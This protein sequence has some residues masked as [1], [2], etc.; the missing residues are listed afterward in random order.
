MRLVGL[1]SIHVGVSARTKKRTWTSGRK[2]QP[3]ETARRCHP[4]CSDPSSRKR[5]ARTCSN[6]LDCREQLPDIS[7]PN[8]N[9]N[10]IVITTSL[11]IQ[12]HHQIWV[13]TLA[14]FGN[15]ISSCRQ[16]S[17]LNRIISPRR[18][19]LLWATSRGGPVARDPLLRAIPATPPITTEGSAADSLSSKTWT[20]CCNRPRLITN[21]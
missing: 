20:M 21:S 19:K 9:A 16:A 13:L 5:I 1:G 6:Q 10:K 3:V 11:N 2:R 8:D 7:T 15:S 17:M 18:S 12:L 14:S 4:P